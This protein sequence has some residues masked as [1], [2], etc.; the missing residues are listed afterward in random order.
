MARKIRVTAEL[1]VSGHNIPDEYEDLPDGWDAW[2]EQAQD[3]YLTGL[4]VDLLNNHA[5]SGAS[6]VEVDENGKEA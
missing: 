6:V 1:Y 5:G 3:E 2:T 4:A